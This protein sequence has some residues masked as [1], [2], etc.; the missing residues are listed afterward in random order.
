MPPVARKTHQIAYVR[1][2]SASTG[3]WFVHPDLRA[4]IVKRAAEKDAS[5]T[6]V[7]VGALA[8]VYG[9][10]FTPSG[11][12]TSASADSDVI[13]MN[14]PISVWNAIG[15]AAQRRGLQPYDELRRALCQSFGLD[16]PTL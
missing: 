16:G 11:R 8:E 10:A 12:K 2:K 13:K 3:R 5:M 6:D 7:A 15:R 14:V 4:V 1:L 9:V